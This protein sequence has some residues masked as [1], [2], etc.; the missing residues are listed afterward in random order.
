MKPG[1]VIICF[2]LL[3]C[4]SCAKKTGFYGADQ[5]QKFNYSEVVGSIKK[6]AQFP[7]PD[8]WAMYQ[9]G[10][11]GINE[12]F[13]TTMQ[14]PIDAFKARESGR[15]TVQFVVETDGYIRKF[16]VISSTHKKFEREA[17]RL[18]LT[19]DQWIPGLI[20]NK[21]VRTLYELPVFFKR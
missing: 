14:Y 11:Q 3:L 10:I 15:V 8:R 19:L 6:P 12:H 20:N 1:E 18:I 4:V 5:Q 16:E 17:V 21:P 2:C 13:E 7:E 9:F